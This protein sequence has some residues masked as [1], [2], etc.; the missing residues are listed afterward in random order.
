MN[1]II[2]LALACAFAAQAAVAQIPGT[3]GLENSQLDDFVILMQQRSYSGISLWF[4]GRADELKPKSPFERAYSSALLALATFSASLDQRS[5]ESDE[6]L[7]RKIFEVQ[8][9]LRSAIVL[10][11]DLGA[12]RRAFAL[13]QTLLEEA[14]M[15][16][17]PEG[18]ALVF[19]TPLALTS[20]EEEI[21]GKFNGL[22]I[23]PGDVVI[24]IGA[25]ALSSHFIAGSQTHPGLASHSYVIAKGGAQPEIL[26]A[27]IEDGVNRRD[28]T[29][30]KLARLWI[31]SLPESKARAGAAKATSDF[32]AKEKIPFVEDGKYGS[33][34]PLRYDSTMNPVRKKD[35]LYFCSALV[36]EI[37]QRAGLQSYQIPY[38]DNQANWNSLDGLEQAV[39]KEL[40]ITAA[41]V[42]AP[43][44]VLM[45]KEFSIRGLMVD[46]GALQT[47]RRMRASVDAL[48][49]ILRSNAAVR[50]Q[51]QA[52]LHAI[53]K[54]EVSKQRILAIL[55][56]AIAAPNGL[57]S[58][59][60]RKVRA[61]VQDNLP[62]TANLRQI[63]FFMT[64]NMLIQD[65]AQEGL[66]A[67]E[68]SELKR[69][70]TPGE[71]RTRAAQLLA[72]ELGKVREGL[73]VIGRVSNLRP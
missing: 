60:L 56:R 68:Q 47:S 17:Y 46:S 12:E 19:D 26:E 39:Y 4:L 5:P 25:N 8:R 51:L 36:Q 23:L 37:Y 21:A 7:A 18:K 64:L 72:G 34:S 33:N 67:F 28:P 14:A 59:I 3:R 65:K 29:D 15:S 70:A 63:A 9:R 58:E 69:H 53:P 10:G 54:M 73:Q 2:Y 52:A 49:D 30:S 50:E 41:R 13:L 22:S 24:Q 66:T 11:S 6:R 43:S 44:D 20:E 71:L 57:D 31:L 35:G 27:L 62:Q 32:I 40:D 48:F 42:P 1:K 16:A 55:D 38:L 61:Q 45:Q